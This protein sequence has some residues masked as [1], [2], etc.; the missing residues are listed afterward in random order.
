[1]LVVRM[2][3]CI[4]LRGSYHAYFQGSLMLSTRIASCLLR[5]L[6]D[7][8]TKVVS[9]L[10]RGGRM[11]ATRVASSCVLRG[12]YHYAWYMGCIMHATAVELC[13]PQ[14]L[15]YAHYSGCIMLA[16]RVASYVLQPG[17]HHHVRYEGCIMHATRIVSY[18][19]RVLHHRAWYDCYN[20]LATRVPCG[21]D[22]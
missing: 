14:G 10:L 9:C 22:D 18:V 21:S 13:C 16:M 15:P 12:S 3:S 4:M 1:M 6:Y 7:H 17:L 20:M 11:C 19:V 8:A 2:A 5:L